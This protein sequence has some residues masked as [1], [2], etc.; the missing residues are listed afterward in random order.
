M[1]A[2]HIVR[3]GKCVVCGKAATRSTTFE[4]TLNPFNK[5]P[6]GSAKSARDIY[7]EL[8]TEAQAWSA[9]PP[10]HVR[11]ESTEDGGR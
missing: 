2:G 6:D 3:A 4:Q 7:R 1:S 10:T 8:E 9:E 5:N 11:C